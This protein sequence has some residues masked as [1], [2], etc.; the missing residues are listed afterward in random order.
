MGEADATTGVSVARRRLRRFRV[1]VLV[2]VLFAVLVATRELNVLADHM[3]VIGLVVGIATAAGAIL[4][5]VWL[6]R[7]VELRPNVPELGADGRWS[8][9]ACGAAIGAT[10]FTVTM[11]LIAVFGGFASLSRGSV[12]G[13]L[14]SFGAFASVAVNEELLFRGVVFRILEERAGT[15][16]ALVGSSLVF[17]LVHLVN[18]GATVAGALAV[19]LQ[20][21]MLT[22]SAYAAT[23]SLWLPIGFHFAWDFV[24]SGIFSAADSGTS[25]DG[26]LRSTL[27]GPTILTGGGFG[28]E[29]SVV[30]LVVCLVPTVL[31]LRSAAR[32]GLLRPRPWAVQSP[33]SPVR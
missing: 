31:L 7:T 15:V 2:V 26:L 12:G 4:F 13:C 10:M 28:P 17:G 21:G 3:A 9:L 11:A 5:Y 18:G 27:S 16:V 30:A 22:A 20:G 29:A 6:S 33:V 19:S 32:N 25:S 14:I 8:G 1:P 23:R 24:E